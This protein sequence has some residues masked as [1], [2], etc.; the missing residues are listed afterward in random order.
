MGS[1]TRETSVPLLRGHLFGGKP[2]LPQKG[3][4]MNGPPND[5]CCLNFPQIEWLFDPPSPN[6]NLLAVACP[7]A[8]ICRIEN[9][10]DE[11]NPSENSGPSGLDFATATR[12]AH[13]LSMF[14]HCHLFCLTNRFLGGGLLH[15]SGQLHPSFDPPFPSI[16]DPLPIPQVGWGLPFW[17]LG[18]EEMA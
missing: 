5:C 8:G 3:S 16:F 18:E 2:S 10:T 9:M 17:L 14:L 15:V 6:L 12:A 7:Y 1:L 13:F 4:K 11:C